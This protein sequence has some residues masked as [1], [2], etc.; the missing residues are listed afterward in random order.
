VP[1]NRHYF[2]LILIPKVDDKIG[3]I[4]DCVKPLKALKAFREFC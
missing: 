4:G 2:M 1:K 3:Q